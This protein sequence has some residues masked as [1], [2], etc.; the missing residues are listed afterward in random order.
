MNQ[1]KLQPDGFEDQEF[2][3]AK[4]LVQSR[5]RFGRKEKSAAFVLNQLLARKG[6][7][8]QQSTSDLTDAWNSIVGIR[9]KNKTRVG[10]INRGILEVIVENPS[11]TQHLNF[12]KQKL[13]TQLQEQLP[14]NKIK[15]IR[16]RVGKF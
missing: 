1:N 7:L 16:F 13:L 9:W 10:N 4:E 2:D 8:Q 15:D 12:Q 6:Y 3:Q 11:V 5:Q 14:Q